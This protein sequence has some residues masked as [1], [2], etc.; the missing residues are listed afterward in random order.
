MRSDFIPAWAIC[1]LLSLKQ[2]IP[3]LP[4]VDYHA[5]PVK[6]VH[7]NRVT[8]VCGHIHT[9]T[10]SQHPPL[11]TLMSMLLDAGA[12]EYTI[13]GG[14]VQTC[15]QGKNTPQCEYEL[16]LQA[17][18]LPNF[19]D[20]NLVSVTSEQETIKQGRDVLNQSFCWYSILLVILFARV[21]TWRTVVHQREAYPTVR[22]HDACSAVSF[23]HMFHNKHKGAPYGS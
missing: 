8:G 9:F 23:L 7:S 11:E 17:D 21:S 1:L 19:T 2:P 13:I 20:T 5:C 18:C 4:K 10:L 22:Q 6:W 14:Y 16:A 12:K 15:M 3:S